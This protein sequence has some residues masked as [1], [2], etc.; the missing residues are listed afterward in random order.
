MSVVL[1]PVCIHQHISVCVAD[2]TSNTPD[3]QR[4]GRRRWGGRQSEREGFLRKVH[5]GQ[6]NSKPM[7]QANFPARSS[8]EGCVCV[9]V[10]LCV[11]KGDVSKMRGQNTHTS[12]SVCLWL[13]IQIWYRHNMLSTVVS[14][15]SHT[16]II[17]NTAL[18]QKCSNFY[19]L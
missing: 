14:C 9:C 2:N 6:F 13:E 4:T 16:C 11:K 12:M 3:R 7:W 17:Q 5:S 18:I 19:I 1:V 15:Y 10:W 8:E